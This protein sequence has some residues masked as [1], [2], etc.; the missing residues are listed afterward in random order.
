M[1]GM[2]S[3]RRRRGCRRYRGDRDRRVARELPDVHRAHHSGD[4]R[5][6]KTQRTR[7]LSVPLSVTPEAS[8]REASAREASAPERRPLSVGS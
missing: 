7:A 2:T 8:A 1:P 3:A 5:A 4:R 6:H